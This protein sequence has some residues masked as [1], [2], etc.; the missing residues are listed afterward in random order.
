V[1]EVSEFCYLGSVI[2]GD[3][4]CDKDIRTRL[5]KANSTFGRLSNIWK[6]K[7]LNINIKS[8]LY[9]ALV[10]SVLLYGAETWPMTVAN[11]K[12]LEAAH[13][14]WQRKLE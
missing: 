7:S 14:R 8:R 3:G 12:R 9:E 10:M 13:H 5:G 2:A 1:E 4:S 6:N 11:M